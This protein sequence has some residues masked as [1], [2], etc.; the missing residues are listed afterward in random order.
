LVAIQQATNARNQVPGGAADYVRR[1]T[2]TRLLAAAALVVS[3]VSLAQ[4]ADAP[5]PAEHRPVISAGADIGVASDYVWRGFLENRTLSVQPNLWMTLGD[6]TVSSWMNASRTGP[7]GR[8]FTERDLTVEYSRT[9]SDWTLS[10]GWTN[11]TF[12]DV[13]VDRYSNEIYGSIARKNYLSPT[14]HIYQDVHQGSGSYVSL[15]VSH[16]Y[17][18]WRSKMTLSPQLSVGYN[19]RQ[20]ID[21]STLSDA[22]LGLT[23]NVPVVGDRLRI[24]PAVNYSK[25]LNASFFEDHL[26]WGVTAS[27]Q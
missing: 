1:M 6:V 8:S 21:A 27:V 4:A 16:E 22:N 20:W 24:A 11:F 26:Y 13:S 12:V 14:L 2:H 5:E 10:G 17:P 15:D 23:L 19:H 3:Q 9:V 18:V 7:N 25:G